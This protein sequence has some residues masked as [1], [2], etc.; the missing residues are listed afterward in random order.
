[1]NYHSF[2]DHIQAEGCSWVRN[3]DTGFG[4]YYH[5]AQTGRTAFLK[6]YDWV[7]WEAAIAFCR[8]AR[9]DIP[10]HLQPKEVEFDRLGL[11]D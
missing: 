10:A 11:S 8:D 5:N 6:E 1:M 3:F 7:P 9:I 2:L 4:A